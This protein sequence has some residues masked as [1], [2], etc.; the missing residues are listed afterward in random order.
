MAAMKLRYPAVLITLFSLF[1]PSIAGAQWGNVFNGTPISTHSGNQLSAVSVSDGAGGAIIAWADNRNGNWDIFAQRVNAWG[2][3]QWAANGVPVRVAL[4]NQT[5]PAI[6][7]DGAQ[8]AVVFYEHLANNGS[9]DIQAQRL[10]AA[11]AQ[12]WLN[13]TLVCSAQHD[14]SSPRAVAVTGGTI[15]VWQDNRQGSTMQADVYVQRVDMSGV[16]QWTSDG[17]AICTATQ[18]QTNARLVS[19]GIGSGGA[20][21]AWSDFRDS[22]TYGIYARRIDNTGLVQWAADGV[23]LGS[24]TGA[25]NP[26]ALASDGAGGAIVTWHSDTDGD[27]DIYAQR[28][29]SSGVVQWTPGGVGVCTASESQIQPQVIAD[30]SG[31]AIMTWQDLRNTVTFSDEDVYAQ[32]VNASGAAQWT[33][34]GVA[35]CTEDGGSV[36]PQIISDAAGGAVVVWTDYRL[37]GADLYTQRVNAAGTVLWATNGTE[38]IL[39]NAAQTGPAPVPDGFGGMIV[40]WTDLRSGT[41]DV[42]ANRIT[43][44]GIIPTPVRDTPVPQSI[45][46][47]VYPNP[48]SASTRIDITSHREAPVNV[49][50][51]DVSGRRVRSLSLAQAG[52]AIRT[53]PFDGR[54]EH[55]TLL[56][57]GLY[58]CRIQSA[59]ETVTRKLVL[60]R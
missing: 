21:I 2:Q 38:V 26:P 39:A 1:H 41:F 37:L 44:G 6:V 24:D 7:S 55:G 60:Q 32:R 50:M 30:G 34:D 56:P 42:Y 15:V 45:A 29:N 48:F 31:G 28:I 40:A 9:T 58:F 43:G 53:I 51:F 52:A 10:N 20:I 11:G 22:S 49:D 8:G 59:G 54:D 47:S 19:D 57:S 5:N 23:L 12:M 27:N 35:L 17:V 4:N 36:Q 13:P 18:K 16:N 25:E 46:V 33:A 14:Q 3:V